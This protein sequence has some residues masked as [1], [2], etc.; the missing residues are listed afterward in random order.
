MLQI[1]SDL[2]RRCKCFE[3][4]CRQSEERCNQNVKAYL[5][6]DPTYD[7]PFGVDLHTY[8]AGTSRKKDSCKNS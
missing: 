1:L 2:P 4:H 3:T 8:G 7:V 6:V 5:G